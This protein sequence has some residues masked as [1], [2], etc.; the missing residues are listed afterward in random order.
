MEPESKEFAAED[1]TPKLHKKSILLVLMVVAIVA[2]LLVLFSDS[3]LFDSD[4]Q[5]TFSELDSLEEYVK[6]QHRIAHLPTRT[7]HVQVDSQFTR[8][9]SEMGV[10][11]LFS[12]SLFQLALN[13]QFSQ[14]GIRVPGK[15]DIQTGELALHYVFEGTVIRSLVMKTDSSSSIETYSGSLAWLIEDETDFQL[16]D[17]AMRLDPDMLFVIYIYSS[18]QVEELIQKDLLPAYPILM[19]DELVSDIAMNRLLEEKLNRIHRLAK[20][21]R[22]FMFNDAH[23]AAGEALWNYLEKEEWKTIFASKYFWMKEDASA[24]DILSGFERFVY[25]SRSDRNPIMILSLSN[26]ST[27]LLRNPL[28]DEKRKGLIIRKPKVLQ[29]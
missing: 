2:S 22:L 17:E 9:V 10:P 21:A 15:Y 7:E 29:F 25:D 12:K 14:Y 19:V 5:L 23:S 27:D 6:R 16:I 20:N 3:P 11:L 28:F 24:G 18:E 1:S 8:K 13:Q 26:A 4:N